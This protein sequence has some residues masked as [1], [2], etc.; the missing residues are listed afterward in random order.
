[1]CIRDRWS[2]VAERPPQERVIDVWWRPNR[3]GEL[4]LLL[5]HLVTRSREWEDAQ[6]RLLAAPAEG[7]DSEA[8]SAAL[9]SKLEEFRIDARIEVIE[10]LNADAIVAHSH[11]SALVFL[12]F[13]IHG[14]RFYGPA[15][16]DLPSLLRAL[17]LV[18]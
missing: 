6:I 14:G 2:K 7:E 15:G 11:D 9:K 17:P 5:A 13:G 16:G 1:M 3:T 8:A 10:D 18:A 12:P 4:M